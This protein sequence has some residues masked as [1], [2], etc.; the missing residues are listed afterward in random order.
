MRT[1]PY[2]RTVSDAHRCHGADEPIHTHSSRNKKE[3]K[4]EVADPK[5]KV[6]TQHG[7]SHTIVVSMSPSARSSDPYDRAFS[8][9]P[10]R[11]VKGGVS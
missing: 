4:R 3:R 11:R 5:P 9:M 7:M 8:P 10:P 1:R 2:V 6:Q